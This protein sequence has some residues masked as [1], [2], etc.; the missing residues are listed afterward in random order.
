MIMNTA[1]NKKI[2]NMSIEE[3]KQYLDEKKYTQHHMDYYLEV[4]QNK[5]KLIDELYDICQK[6][7]KYIKDIIELK[8]LAEDIN[9]SCAK[10]ELINKRL[11]QL[12]KEIR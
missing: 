5:N 11:L 4:I 8:G 1:L 6:Q 10:T 7:N 9:I 12:A 2:E 3:L